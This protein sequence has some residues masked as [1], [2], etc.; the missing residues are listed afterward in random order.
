MAIE[1]RFQ[2]LLNPSP[3]PKGGRKRSP[4][5]VGYTRTLADLK[6]ELEHLKAT[7]VVIEAQIDRS[8]I[9][10]DGFPYSSAK[11]AGP[12]VAV[13]FDSVHGPLRY[14]CGTYWEWEQNLRAISLT[15]T[16]LRAVDRYGATK[17]A[18][19][20]RGFAALPPVE[21]KPDK[22][23]DPRAAAQWL[24]EFAGLSGAIGW[25]ATLNTPDVLTN[26]WRAAVMKAHPDH[27]G[28]AEL[29]DTV[30]KVRNVIE[31][32]QARKASG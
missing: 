25:T 13:S 31:L 27:G 18:E 30:N 24:T 32:E 9:R 15:L 1:I 3:A 20:Y 4:F 2:P 16:A 6:R 29:M 12:T 8:Q 26:V 11:F 28:T 17:Q 7:R 5:A 19:Q 10:N 21:E 23:K 22:L 14:E